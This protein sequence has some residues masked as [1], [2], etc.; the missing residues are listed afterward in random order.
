[1]GRKRIYCKECKKKEV[2]AKGMC[3]NCYQKKRYQTLKQAPQG[4][5][6]KKQG[7]TSKAEI[8]P[9]K[10]LRFVVEVYSIE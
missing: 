10:R 4:K 1:M 5:K 2:K 7:K 6:A 9:K 3:W 8:M